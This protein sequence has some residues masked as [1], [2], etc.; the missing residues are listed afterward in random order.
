MNNVR[1]SVQLIGNLGREVQYKRLDNGSSLARVSLATRD[2]FRNAQ[3]EKVVNV[4]WHQL[5]GWGKT[6]E[7][8]HKLLQKGQEIAVK[9]KLTQH[10]YTDREGRKRF[11]SEVVVNEFLLMNRS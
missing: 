5:V 2:V 6:A 11:R 9:G 1:N 4:Q 3:G 10:S 8:M 7:T